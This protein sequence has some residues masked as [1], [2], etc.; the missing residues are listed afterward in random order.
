MSSGTARKHHYVPEF[1]LRRWAVNGELRGYYWDR[2]KLDVRVKVL[3]VG[4]F[5]YE[6]DLLSLGTNVSTDA[7]ETRFFG[8]VDDYGAKVADKLAAN[9]SV[10]LSADERSHFARLLLSLDAR[11]PF[12]VAAL[13]GAAKHFAEELDQDR[14]IQ[15]AFKREGIDGKPSTFLCERS[16][17][18]LEDRALLIIQKL[19]DNPEVGTHLI[20]AH[21]QVYNIGDH[22]CSLVLSDRPLIRTGAYDRPKTVWALPLSPKMLFVA[23]NSPTVIQSFACQTPSRLRKRMNESS[24]NQVDR[25][26]FMIDEANLPLVNKRLRMRGTE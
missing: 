1:I 20:N 12:N 21:W 5:C 16:Q 24:L 11:R 15:E 17:V 4:G 7:L 3:G 10:G 22:D 9:G 26:V 23:S 19:V 25:Y 13:K 8:A 6:L 2:Y 18:S 14:E